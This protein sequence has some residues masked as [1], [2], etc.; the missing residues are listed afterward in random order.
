MAWRKVGPRE[1]QGSQ[2]PAPGRHH[3]RGIDLMSRFDD[4]WNA[5]DSST[6]TANAKPDAINS[7]SQSND[8]EQGR[9][10][11]DE[12]NTA[13]QGAASVNNQREMARQ[14]RLA[15]TIE[16]EIIPRLLLAHLANKSSRQPEITQISPEFG[17]DDRQIVEFCTIIVKS[18]V[19]VAIQFIDRLRAEGMSTEM[20]LLEVLTPAARYLGTE[21]EEDKLS[22]VDVTLGLSRLQQ[23]LRVYSSSFEADI[24]TAK[25]P[26]G[27]RM[28][29]SAM[30]GEQHTFGMSVVEEFFRRG[31]WEVTSNAMATRQDLLSCC[32]DQWFDV[33]GL[34][35][36][37]DSSVALL[38]SLIRSIRDIALNRSVR[39]IVG[40]CA[41]LNNPDN[42]V[43]LGADLGAAN[44]R[45]AVSSVNRLFSTM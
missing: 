23:L 30:P 20:V 9:W 36:S 2:I 13:N 7:R 39:V 10:Q 21:W 42:A 38:P 12:T 27:R 41:F 6:S 33:V 18:P 44:G 22:F 45:D 8:N 31:G 19:R 35:A 4:A 26:S 1:E 3:L 28:L 29:L 37:G 24:E 15:R 40:G 5:S 17:F 14:D 25:K 43:E 16:A 11:R 34:S 32:R